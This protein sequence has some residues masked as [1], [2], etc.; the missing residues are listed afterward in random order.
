MKTK[1]EQN[2]SHSQERWQ[3]LSINF[4]YFAWICLKYLCLNSTQNLFKRFPVRVVF[5]EHEV[6]VVD[7]GTFLF[8]ES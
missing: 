1:L 3:D 6:E 2:I 8:Y 5:G 7:N 4:I